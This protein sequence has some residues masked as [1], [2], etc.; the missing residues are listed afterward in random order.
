MSWG[1]ASHFHV[2][3]YFSHVERLCDWKLGSGWQQHSRAG[4]EGPSASTSAGSDTQPQP[5]AQQHRCVVYLASDDPAVLEE[6][7]QKYPH[8][9]VLVNKAG[10]ETGE[11]VGAGRWG[12]VWGV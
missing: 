8:I 10:A 6:V 12:G 5:Q 11:V 3:D 4:G 1:R 2:E 7:R 9:A